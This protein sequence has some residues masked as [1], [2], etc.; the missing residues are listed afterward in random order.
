LPGELHLSADQVCSRLI[1]RLS[2][3]FQPIREDQPEPVIL[4]ML[5]DVGEKGKDLRASQ[6]MRRGCHECAASI[7]LSLVG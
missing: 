5:L 4:W 1:Q 6:P 7:R 2:V 3:L